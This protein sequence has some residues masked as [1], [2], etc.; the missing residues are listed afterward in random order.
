MDE[1]HSTEKRDN[2]QEPMEQSENEQEIIRLDRAFIG[3]IEIE[4]PEEPAEPFTRR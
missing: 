1:S 4:H 2:V 3:G